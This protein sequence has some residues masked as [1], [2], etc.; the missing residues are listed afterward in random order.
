MASSPASHRHSIACTNAWFAPHVTS[1][2]RPAMS[3]P[4]RV[5]SLSCSAA[6]SSGSP[7]HAPYPLGARSACATT[8]AGTDQCATPGA[9]L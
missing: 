8:V 5:C 7:S 9:R 2:L 1:T 3:M 6:R 4:L